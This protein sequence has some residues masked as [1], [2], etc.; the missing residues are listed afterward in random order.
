MKFNVLPAVKF[1]AG[2][3]EKGS[4]A[5]HKVTVDGKEQI[6]H[7]K[8]EFAADPLLTFV[9]IY[10]SSEASKIAF[11]V[12]GEGVAGDVL[13]VALFCCAPTM[14]MPDHTPMYD[15][16]EASYH[17]HSF[18]PMA[19][20]TDVPKG[21]YEGHRHPIE[22]NA[23]GLITGFGEASGHAHPL[24]SYMVEMGKMFA[25][26]M[27]S[28]MSDTELQKHMDDMQKE[29]DALREKMKDAS[30]DMK[31]DMQEDMDSLKEKMA[32]AKAE[33]KKR[34]SMAKMAVKKD[35]DGDEDEDEDEDE[36]LYTIEGV[37]IFAVGKWNGD[38]YTKADLEDMVAAFEEVS[39]QVP[40]TLGHTNKA[41]AP[42]YG[43]VDSIKMAGDRLVATFRDIPKILYDAIKGRRFDAVSSEIFWNLERNGKKFRRVLKAVAVLGAETPGVDLA[44]LRTVVNSVLPPSN[45]YDRVSV[46]TI[47]TE[48][49][50]MDL[51]E[52]QE[53]IRSLQV[54]LEAANAA[55]AEAEAKAKDG[56][57]AE[58]TKLQEAT[59]K[60]AQLQTALDDAQKQV[61]KLAEE[62]DK[63]ITALK[64]QLTQQGAAIASMQESQRQKDVKA[65]V[66][67]VPVPIL[68]PFFATLYDTA[69]SGTSP[70]VVKFM[71]ATKDA[72]EEEL[73]PVALLDKMVDLLRGESMKMFREFSQTTPTIREEGE[74]PMVAKFDG[75]PSAEVTKRAKAYMAEHKT[76]DFK[77]AAEAILGADEELRVAY[78]NYTAGAGV[79]GGRQ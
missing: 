32:D 79:R 39:F 11:G 10:K 46:Y 73:S 25:M 50:D 24:P 28:K 68:K 33:M 66:D 67:R 70:K 64:A 51:K 63:E 3:L 41:G 22:R 7:A 59:A 43:W 34:P 37:E 72:K 53:K 23:D 19:A 9:S 55:K 26:M 40:I 17:V 47:S 52:L 4:V 21:M 62:K 36:E 14:P 71:A 76:K 44:P 18:Q 77:A 45:G 57:A 8:S 65:K 49:L 6:L 31:P 54:D 12:G 56:S 27:P 69:T 2:R 1:E 74:D 38:D 13:P 15:T 60:V 48:D 35:D 42:A 30:A 75:D 58:A 5:V 29:M 78:A 16:G 61:T 20:F